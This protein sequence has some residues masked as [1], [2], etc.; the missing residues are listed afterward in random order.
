MADEPSILLTGGAGF[1]GRYLAPALAASFP[2]HRRVILCLEGGAGLPQGWQCEKADIT[3]EAAVQGIVARHKPGIVVHL[4]A[5]SSAGQSAHAAEATWRV[6]FG[7]FFALASAVARHSPG[8]VFLFVSSSECL[9][10][11]FRQGGDRGHASR[12]AHPLRGLQAR[13]GIDTTRCAFFVI[14]AH[15]RARLQP[16][17][18]G[19]G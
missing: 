8:G 3:D 7:G 17:R 4:A 19:A 9:R 14:Q 10:S 13:R 16:H 11:S 6:N 15:Y 5:Q 1:V 18:P 2:H 12:A